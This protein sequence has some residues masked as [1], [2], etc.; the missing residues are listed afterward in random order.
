MVTEFND[1]P[2]SKP[3]G[4][5]E[6]AEAEEE[7]T[8]RFSP[9]ENWKR[10][11]YEA[12]SEANH[13]QITFLGPLSRSALRDLGIFPAIESKNFVHGVSPLFTRPPSSP[14]SPRPPPDLVQYRL[15]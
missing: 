2:Q 1:S 5:S 15:G 11:F 7:G 6:D 13:V 4:E 10:S 12:K 14:M 9:A 8:N 3:P